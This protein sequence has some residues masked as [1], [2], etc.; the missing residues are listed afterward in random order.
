[1]YRNQDLTAENERLRKENRELREKYAD[2]Q[3]VCTKFCSPAKHRLTLSLAT[4]LA[5][6]Y[7]F[8][9]GATFAY[10]CQKLAA[11]MCAQDPYSLSC[12]WVRPTALDVYAVVFWPAY[13]PFEAGCYA[14]AT[15]TVDQE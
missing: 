6:L 14:A 5:V 13:W 2:A 4:L 7:L 1:M 3:S 8:I 15:V 9:G 11:T 12:Q 10:R